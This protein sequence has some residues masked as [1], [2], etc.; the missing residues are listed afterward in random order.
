LDRT[1]TGNVAIVDVHHFYGDAIKC[2]QQ[3]TDTE[4]GSLGADVTVA[5]AA[6]ESIADSI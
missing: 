1:L 6:G 2:H 5:L 3:E 4:T